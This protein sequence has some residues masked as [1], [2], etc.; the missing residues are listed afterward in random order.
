MADKDKPNG[1]YWWVVPFYKELAPVTRKVNELTPAALIAPHGKQETQG[2]IR[3]LKLIN[4]SECWFHSADREDSL[5]GSGLNGM[6]IDEAAKLKETRWSGELEPSL[7][8]FNGWAD[9]IGTAK[10]KNWFHKLYCKGLDP[11]NPLYASFS[12][13]SYENTIERGGFLEKQSIDAIAEDMPEFLRKQEI[14]GEFLEGEGEVFRFITR[15]I[16]EGIE[17]FNPE[18]YVWIGADFGKTMDYTVLI[19]LNEKGEL[20]G[21]DRFNRIDWSFQ[22]GR[23]K[24]FCDRFNHYVLL[25]DA[26]GVGDPIYDGLVNAGVQVRP[27]KFTNTSKQ[28]IIENLSHMLDEGALWFP[29]SIQRR[30]FAVEY[31]ALQSELEA[32]S[33]EIGSTGRIFYSAPEGSHDDCVCSLAL[34]AWELKN[35]YAPSGLGAGFINHND[36]EGY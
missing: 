21:F 1:L 25:V 26:T 28:E 23:V 30:E 29:G 10:G 22:L 18:H 11:F 2:M 14:Y 13:S 34:A 5:R 35:Q 27:F 31:R 6:V 3:R 36:N 15:Q 20:V 16:R 19:A 12:F 33:Y 7:I 8:D 4:G 32:F 17:Q 24:S 9:F